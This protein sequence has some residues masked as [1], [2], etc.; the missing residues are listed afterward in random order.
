M[1]DIHTCTGVGILVFDENNREVELKLGGDP[2]YTPL[3][4]EQCNACM[5][6][7]GWGEGGT[8]TCTFIVV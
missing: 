7:C 1:Y 3:V 2:R 5:C 8:R 4:Y 6:V